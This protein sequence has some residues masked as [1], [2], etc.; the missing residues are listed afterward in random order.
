MPTG[1]GDEKLWL[2]P[3]LDDSADDLSGTGNDGTYQG[4]IGTVTD[5]GNGGSL[6]YNMSTTSTS[7]IELPTTLNNVLENSSTFT[8]WFKYTSPLASGDPETTFIGPL[9]NGIGLDWYGVVRTQGSGTSGT[10]TSYNDDGS[11]NGG[12]GFTDTVGEDGNWHHLSVTRDYTTDTAEIYI[13]GLSI[14]SGSFSSREPNNTQSHYIGWMNF[15]G[16]AGDLASSNELY[17]D[18]I[19][20]YDRVV[21]Q[22]EVTYLATSR[23]IQ[24][25][26]PTIVGLGDEKLWILPSVTSTADNYALDA[27]SGSSAGVGTVTSNV[28]VTT[29]PVDSE[30]SLLFNNTS[31]Q[32]YKATWNSGGY[33][34]YTVSYWYRSTDPGRT[35]IL[36]NY[37]GSTGGVS[38]LLHYHASSDALWQW[39][40]GT[41]GVPTGY[42]DRDGT[43]HHVAVQRQG[44]GSGGVSKYYY[45]GVLVW[46]TVPNGTDNGF[47]TSNWMEIGVANPGTGREAFNWLGSL[48]DFRVYD[49]LLTD[50]EITH[51]ASE[52]GASGGPTDGRYN[53]F[54]NIHFITRRLG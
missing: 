8:C 53:P 28:T 37:Q 42:L 10:I 54:V 44:F 22:R 16:Y 7:R 50:E 4:G 32:S 1:L 26:P 31:T 47:W 14:G 45:D 51:L 43:W 2:C 21:T 52:R 25:A 46:D 48:D 15:F 29:D 23:G 9:D 5:T 18:D 33:S 27:A 12:V 39:N 40:D 41:A 34:T 24:G 13:D 3:S 11:N 35:S 17:F 49:R 36:F 38:Y 6:A 20:V 19:R 30:D